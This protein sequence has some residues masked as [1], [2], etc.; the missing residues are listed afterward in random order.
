MISDMG[1]V[2]PKKTSI[3]LHL[4]DL[5]VYTGVPRIRHVEPQSEK[6]TTAK[7]YYTQVTSLDRA[8]STKV[9]HYLK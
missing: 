6:D 3:D 1:S 4:N 9:S 8:L 7:N 5:C 2:S